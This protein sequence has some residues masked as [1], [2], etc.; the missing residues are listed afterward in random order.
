[1]II[2]VHHLSTVSRYDIA[3]DIWES[4]LPQL[5]LAR[6]KH[7]ACVLQAK[8]YVFCGRL[9]NNCIGYSYLN[10]IEVIRETDLVP[11]SQARWQLIEVSESI[12]AKRACPAVTAINDTEIAILGG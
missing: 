5:I 8:V 3:K 4:G 2:G 9:I 11:H 6:N 12:L 10:S 7:S 1:M